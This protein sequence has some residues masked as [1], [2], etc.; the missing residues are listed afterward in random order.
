MATSD[1]YDSIDTRLNKLLPLLDAL[2]A[3][4][5]QGRW[6]H[7]GRGSRASDPMMLVR[8]YDTAK[9]GIW[10]ALESAY[11]DGY[12]AAE[13]ERKNGIPSPAITQEEIDSHVSDNKMSDTAEA[14]TLSCR[15]VALAAID[16][17]FDG[18]LDVTFMSEAE[19]DCVWELF[20][21]CHTT[22]LLRGRSRRIQKLSGDIQLLI[23][24]YLKEEAAEKAAAKTAAYQLYDPAKG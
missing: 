7:G 20:D 11:L 15:D 18:I 17:K 3:A 16:K 6:A 13:D 1:P 10:H 19:Q 4:S 8:A 24:K 22:L 12:N 21:Q 23:N 2:N 14:T 5:Q 9:Q